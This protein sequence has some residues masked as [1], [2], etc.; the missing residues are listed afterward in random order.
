MPHAAAHDDITLLRQSISEFCRKVI[1]PL[2][3]EIH[4]TDAFPKIIWSKLAKMG[5][6]G[7]T[8]EQ[9]YGGTGLGYLE[10]VIAMEEIS[11]TSPSVGLS[12]AAHSNLCANQIRLHGS[13][14][15]KA[16]YLPKLCSGEWIGALAMSETHA[17]SDVM[18]MSLKAEEQEHGFVFNGTKMWITNGSDADVFVIYARTDP[19][20][21]SK[22]ISAFIVEKNTLG[23]KSA[24]KIDKLGMR[25][26][27]TAELVFQQCIVPKH[28]LLGIK[29]QG[30]GILMAGLNYERIV[31]AGGPLGI[32]KACLDVVI[33]YVRERK[34]FDRSIGEF[35]LIQAKLADMYTSYC[36][37]KAY[38][39]DVA[40]RCDQGLK[41]RKEAA[42]AILFAAEQAT[43][44][45]S[46]AIQCLGG[47]G[48]TTD[49]PV[50]QLWRDAKLYEIGAGTSEI[51]RM[52]IGRELFL[53]GMEHDF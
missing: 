32:M 36:S 46:Q 44:V 4:E 8:I 6:L 37:A 33:P 38:V 19:S 1:Q 47:N 13:E 3:K 15:Q 53:E 18:S 11:R 2:S 49:Y 25:G 48:Y 14:H 26:S 41:S 34:Q 10:H 29:N 31:L 43:A 7:I 17:G 52:L 16:A 21:K 50:E 24:Q 12:Y 39:Y 40:K 42:S 20:Q 5:L 35:Q 22:G 45:A 27:N 9:Q 23:F 51:R 30:A 28:N